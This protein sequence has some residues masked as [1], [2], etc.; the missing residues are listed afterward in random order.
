[1]KKVVLSVAI[2]SFALL[3]NAQVLKKDLLKD[4]KPGDQLEKAVYG[5]KKEPI[6]TDSWNGAFS[7]NP[8]EGVGSPLVGKALSYKGYPEGGLSIDIGNFPADIKGSRFSVYSLTDVNKEYRKG[9]YYLAFLANF[10]K[11]DGNFIDPTAAKFKDFNESFKDRDGRLLAT[12]MHSDCKY[13]SMTVKGAKKM[14][15]KAYSEE[16][17]DLINPPQI[18]STG[19]QSNTTGYHIRMGIDTT[20]V[21]G[22]GETATPMIRYAEALL[23]YAE[24]AEEL[25][26]CGAAVLEKTRFSQSSFQ[27]R[28]LMLYLR[29]SARPCAVFY[30]RPYP[31]LIGIRRICYILYKFFHLA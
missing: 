28:G 20:F 12:V 29:C 13:K 15:V 8:L 17:K 1:M 9:T 14:L 6:R 4:Y 22:Q 23:A 31:L 30:I 11:L 26:K 7:T 24:A 19:N 3:A 18:V 5:D 2:M 16:D 21:S 10:S 27:R 25:G